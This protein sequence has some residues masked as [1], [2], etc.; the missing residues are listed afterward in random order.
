MKSNSSKLL[1]TFVFTIV[2]TF[3]AY[4]Q[5]TNKNIIAD[6]KPPISIKPKLALKGAVGY[7]RYGKQYHKIILTVENRNKFSAKM[8]ELGA[9]EKLQPNPCRD[10][11]KTRIVMFVFSER[12][13]PIASCLAIS[14]R[15]A[16][17][18]PLFLI[19]KGKAIP[20]FVYIV[21]T[22]LKTGAKY[23]SNLVSPFGGETK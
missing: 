7:E 19:E 10:K 15:D 8:F 5:D 4:A 6:P 2:F 1:A 21:L 23:K 13:K 11:V 22:D 20:G 18:A 9:G 12:G 14:S 3:A 16:L 17:E